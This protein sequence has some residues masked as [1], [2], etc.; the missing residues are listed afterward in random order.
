MRLDFGI[1]RRRAGLLAISLA[2]L[3]G[4][5]VSAQDSRPPSD[6]GIRVFTQAVVNDVPLAP[7]LDTIIII[8]DFFT[9][10]EDEA[11]DGK[12]YWNGT[13][14]GELG[15]PGDPETIL[16]SGY[17]FT[18]LNAVVEPGTESLYQQAVGFTQ[19]WQA[20][21]SGGMAGGTFELIVDAELAIS[22]GISGDVADAEF[23]YNFGVLGTLYSALGSANLQRDGHFEVLGDLEVVEFASY[24]QSHQ[25][26][27]G[28]V[29]QLPFTVPDGEFDVV[30]SVSASNGWLGGSAQSLLSGS[31]AIVGNPS[32]RFNIIPDAG[33]SFEPIEVPEPSTGVSLLLG[34]AFL[35]VVF[36]GRPDPTS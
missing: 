26:R 9:S 33:S 35:V 18:A 29:V 19:T 7:P 12:L 15:L 20:D 22:M 3:V 16:D 17:G 27:V 1:G 10:T 31:A 30:A 23:A 6:P 32:L 36:R 2:L 21:S 5:L 13:L 28:K 25:L 11:Q 24:A 34:S 14:T 8:T 4:G